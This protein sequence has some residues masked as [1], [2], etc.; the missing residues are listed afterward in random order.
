M[1]EELLLLIIRAFHLL[2]PPLIKFFLHLVIITIIQ[3]HQVLP[4]RRLPIYNVL[5]ALVI[6]VMKEVQ[7]NFQ[8]EIN[9]YVLPSSMPG[10]LSQILDQHGIPQVGEAT[11]MFLELS[12]YQQNATA[13][14]L[15]DIAPVETHDD[16]VTWAQLSGEVFGL[17]GSGSEGWLDFFAT[18]GFHAGCDW[19]HF[20]ARIDRQPVSCSSVFLAQRSALISN[21]AT[22]TTYRRRG[23]GRLV[24]QA[25]MVAGL[26]AGKQFA[27]LAS[28]DLGL[29][30]YR[31]LG[32]RE[33]R[34]WP[35]HVI[36]P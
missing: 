19:R 18:Q 9:W 32:F 3:L 4:I 34:R 25:A 7:N 6:P 12:R 13:A 27:V 15:V 23:L 1:L 29:G 17:Q 11:D 14:Q 8:T 20:L 5:P 21:V 28:S 16:L 35:T 10:D 30:V 2:F 36:S 26:E 31:G 22:L 24:T 33:G